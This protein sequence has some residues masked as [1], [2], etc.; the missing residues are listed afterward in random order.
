MRMS[1]LWHWQDRDARRLRRA[2]KQELA[3]CWDAF[4]LDAE[5]LVAAAELARSEN[6]PAWE[7]FYLH[8]YVQ[9]GLFRDN[10]N[11]QRLAP[12]V[13][14]LAELVE[15]PQVSQCPQRFCGRESVFNH[16]M[17]ADPPGY[18]A[19]VLEVS[20]RLAMEVPGH[21]ECR[22]CFELL[23]VGS[24]LQLE[25]TEEAS[26]ALDTIAPQPGD[27]NLAVLLRLYR[28]AVLH[29]KG[30]QAGLAE[31]LRH[32][33]RILDSGGA[34]NPDNGWFLVEMEVLASILAGEVE[35]AAK[36]AASNAP[37]ALSSEGIRID[38]ALAEAFAGQGD[39]SASRGAAERALKSSLR[40]GMVR[41]AAEAG[42]WAAEACA[43]LGEADAQA[44]HAS[45]LG[46]LLPQL[47]S[48]DLDERARGVGADW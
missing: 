35:H 37:P 10:E 27:D 14:R 39:W 28:A 16:R 17:M 32:A 25:R 11:L 47:R 26:A 15:S 3:R 45:Q 48:R 5:A 43:H 29:Q 21:L 4:D 23:Q 18:A 2:G 42:V 20:A 8:W 30:D 6:E 46:L 41:Y 13:E 34:V 12:A 38:L 36:R 31:E 24:L 1:G 7:L 40:R 33:R 9:Q 22:G 19:E 44:D